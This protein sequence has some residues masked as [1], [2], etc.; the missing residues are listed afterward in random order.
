MGIP[1]A[2]V[3]RTDIFL[4]DWH[5]V[6]VKYLNAESVPNESIEAHLKK[7][8]KQRWDDDADLLINL[9]KKNLEN[10]DIKSVVLNEVELID[11]SK[12]LLNSK[13]RL[14]DIAN[15]VVIGDRDLKLNQTDT[16]KF[17]FQG[18][19]SVTRNI[20]HFGDIDELMQSTEGVEEAAT[21]FSTGLYANY[22]VIE[23][24]ELGQHELTGV[25]IMVDG[26]GERKMPFRYTYR[27]E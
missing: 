12:E 23:A 1:Y 14:F 26:K 10:S 17:I 27:V 2:G 9:F 13:F 4:R 19:S 11:M 16:I 22:H 18:S 8:E 24:T 3:K 7:L 6:I 15:P 21:D 20:I 5:K 25:M